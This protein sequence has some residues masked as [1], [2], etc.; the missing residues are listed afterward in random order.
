MTALSA[1]LCCS[2]ALA[3]TDDVT[4]APEARWKVQRAN[5]PMKSWLPHVG[6]GPVLVVVLAPER[7]EHVRLSGQLKRALAAALTDEDIPALT[8]PVASL[9]A[10]GAVEAAVKR[11]CS[12]VLTARVLGTRSGPPAVSF[13]LASPRGDVLTTAELTTVFGPAPYVAYRPALSPQKLRRDAGT[14]LFSSYAVRVVMFTLTHDNGFSEHHVELV[15]PVNGYAN[16][17]RLCRAAQPEF[18]D[19]DLVCARQGPA[20]HVWSS[21]KMPRRAEQL[22]L[23]GEL[24]NQRVAELLGADTE[25][26]GEPYFPIREARKKKSHTK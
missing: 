17:Q 9:S 13:R 24:Y 19:E 2:L 3:Q 16:A 5:L 20:N 4:P 23:L 22:V 26:F 7:D 8:E 21:G 6:R 14:A 18:E 12:S 25:E 1:L 10:V 15:T 11:E